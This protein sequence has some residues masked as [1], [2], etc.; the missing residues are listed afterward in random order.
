MQLIKAIPWG[1]IRKYLEYSHSPAALKINNLCVHIISWFVGKINWQRW[2]FVHFL[3]PNVIIKYLVPRISQEIFVFPSEYFIYSMLHALFLMSFMALW[4]ESTNILYALTSRRSNFS[5]N[6]VPWTPFDS[7]GIE[8]IQN[9][10][11]FKSSVINEQTPP[12]IACRQEGDWPPWLPQCGCEGVPAWPSPARALGT[13]SYT[14][15]FGSV[16]NWPID[17]EVPTGRGKAEDCQEESVM[18]VCA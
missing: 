17:P 6:W 1:D 7:K 11:R 14:A 5:R 4:G 3:R 15:F 18:Y 9:L 12:T 10:S 13:Q 16:Q 8:D 2:E